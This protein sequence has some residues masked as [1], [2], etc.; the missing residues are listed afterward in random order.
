[1]ALC[2]FVLNIMLTCAGTIAAV[3]L[4]RYMLTNATDPI[5]DVCKEGAEHGNNT[6]A[7]ACMD[8]W[9]EVIIPRLQRRIAKVKEMLDKAL[10]NTDDAGNPFAGAYWAE[11]DYH[12]P[13]WSTAYWGKATYARLLE[14][15]RKYDPEGLFICRH[16]V[17]SEA[18]TSE[19]NLNCRNRTMLAAAAEAAVGG[20]HASSNPV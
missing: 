4:F 7:I 11:T 20:K 14:V 19:S 2:C 18:W 16:C 8:H 13:D 17:G 15:K 6:A 9:T 12:E 5:R 3:P 1:M 10:P